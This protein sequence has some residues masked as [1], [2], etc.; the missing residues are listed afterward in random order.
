VKQNVDTWSLACVYSEHQAWIQGGFEGPYGLKAYREKRSSHEAIDPALGACFHDKNGEL[1]PVVE[2]WHNES[3]EL[4][5]TQ[6]HVSPIIW[7]DLLRRMFAHSSTR[8]DAR[9]SLVDSQEVVASAL[10]RLE[11]F[12]AWQKLS[13]TPLAPQANSPPKTPPQV[14]DGYGGTSS[15]TVRAAL[16]PFTDHRTTKKHDWDR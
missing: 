11:D 7:S 10:R 16:S 8:L 6:D 12:R 3:L 15:R 1:L 9:Q 13:D 2:D 4:C 5:A 14:P